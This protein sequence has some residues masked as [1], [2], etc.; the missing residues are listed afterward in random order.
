M[1]EFSSIDGA[2]H[3]RLVCSAVQLIGV[4]ALYWLIGTISLQQSCINMEDTIIQREPMGRGNSVLVLLEQPTNRVPPYQLVAV[5]V[6][7]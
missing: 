2:R 3:D 1:G 6:S 7:G 4:A 5:P